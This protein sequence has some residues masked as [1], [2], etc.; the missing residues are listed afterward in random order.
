MDATEHVQLLEQ[1]IQSQKMETVGT[2]AGGMAH[3]FNNL[4]TAIQGFA[5]LLKG[6]LTPGS[7][8]YDSVVNIE[9]ASMR[10]PAACGN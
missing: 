7:D 10:R 8:D 6:S 4:L 9:H 2:L 3:D 1:L 5:G